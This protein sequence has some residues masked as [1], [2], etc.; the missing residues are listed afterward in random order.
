MLPR[1]ATARGQK[2]QLACDCG[3]GTIFS[4][5][6]NKIR[7][8]SNFVN[9]KHKGEFQRRKYLQD[10]CGPYLGLVSE[11]LEGVAKLRY[12]N[13]GLVRK[14]LCPFFRFLWE[15]G[16]VSL[17]DVVPATVT[18]FQ[19]WARENGF[20]SAATDTSALSVFFQWLIVEER[21]FEDSPVIPAIHGKRKRARTGRPYSQEDISQIRQLLDVRGNERLRAFFEIANESGLR[22]SEIYRLRLEDLVIEQRSLKVGLPNKS[23]TE[24]LAFF[25]DRASCRILEW[26]SVRKPDCG[27]GFLF[28]NHYGAPLLRNTTQEEFKRIL[29]KM[30]RGRMAHETGLETF[31]IHRLRHTLASKLAS[32]GADA[33]TLM[34]V[35]GWVSPSSLE[36]YT[37]LSEEAKVQGFVWASERAEQQLKNGTGKRT[38]TAEEFLNGVPDLCAVG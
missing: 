11:Y 32:N 14:L 35:L 18:A 7:F 20:A 5:Y 34:N 25:G 1:P 36:S 4:R 27:H 31:S 16:I 2:V 6:R 21:Y 24:R 12:R 3:C 33:N 13:V 37:R 17:K 28:H 8:K 30:Y 22:K 15:R 9:V 38:L 19:V 23:M 26:L 10:H 29:C